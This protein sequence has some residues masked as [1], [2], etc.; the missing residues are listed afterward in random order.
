MMRIV[1]RPRPEP[2]LVFTFV[3]DLKAIVK[4][5]TR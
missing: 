1:G 4:G 5:A 2:A 3:D